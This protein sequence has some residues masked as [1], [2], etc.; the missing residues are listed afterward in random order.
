MPDRVLTGTRARNRRVDL[1]LRQAHV[2]KVVGIS[3]SY[4]NLIEHNRRRIG[5]KLL[6]DLAQVLEIDAALLVDDTTD[7]I[8]LPIK[9]AAAAFPET[10]VEDARAEELIARFPGWAAL[11]AAQRRRIAQLEERTEALSNRLAHD[12]QIANS[13]HDVISTATAIR[14]TASIL[15]ETPDLDREWQSRFH[16][17]IDTDSARLAQSSQALLGFL[18]MEMEAGNTQTES[19][20]ERAEAEMTKAGFYFPSVDAGEDQRFDDVEDPSARILLRDWAKVASKDAE[21]LP[22]EAFSQAARATAYDPARLAARF[23]V[24]LDMV[25]RRLAHLPNDMD[26]PLM[27]LAVCDAAGVVTFQKPVLDFRLPRS[28]AACPLWPLYQAL[29][30]PGRAIRR[31]VRLPG[32]AHTPFECFAIATPVG[33]ASFAAEPRITATMLVR[34]ARNDDMPDTVGPGCRVC[35]VKDCASRRH[36]RLN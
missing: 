9:E 7:A 27:G 19:P 15:A 29:T 36:P 21:R 23:R 4:L 14:S 35:A 10:T 18:D 17:N 34:S 8:L 12:S 20:M 16:T 24:P 32:G 22:L 11:V 5:G 3:G 31:V 26:H 6:S 25:F 2:A 30:Q 1:G 28:G 33:E 13:L